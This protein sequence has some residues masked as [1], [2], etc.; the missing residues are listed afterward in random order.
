MLRSNQSKHNVVG[1]WLSQTQMTL[2]TY[3]FQ[4]WVLLLPGA[5]IVGGQTGSGLPP[6]YEGVG[7]PEGPLTTPY[8]KDN[9]TPLTSAEAYNPMTR[10]GCSVGNLNRKRHG[11][12]MCNNMVCG[13]EWVECQRDPNCTGDGCTICESQ[14]GTCEKFDGISTFKLLPVRLI[15]GW[16]YHL[17]WGLKSGDVLLLGH[18]QTTERVSADGS[19]SSLDFP[20]PYPLW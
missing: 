20:L 17:C 16:R 15:G 4:N 9:S 6:T 18:L 11:H 3:D 2:S 8:F 7:I 12:T 10:R 19:S 13:G 1:W 5:I 14:E